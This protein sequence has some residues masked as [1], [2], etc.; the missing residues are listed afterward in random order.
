MASR[1]AEI[2]SKPVGSGAKTSFSPPV[3]PLP[4]AQLSSPSDVKT[5]IDVWQKSPPMLSISLVQFTSSELCSPPL[6]QSVCSQW[7]RV[8]AQHLELL[9]ANR[10]SERHS[11]GKWLGKD[12]RGGDEGS[13]LFR[14]SCCITRRRRCSRFLIDYSLLTALS[15][16]IGSYRFSVRSIRKLLKEKVWS[17]V[18]FQIKHHFI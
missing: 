3:T 4:P 2:S 15:R 5:A 7:Q 13:H 18:N 10:R 12:P 17:L 8:D 1:F 11:A 14:N 9:T 6:S 16:L